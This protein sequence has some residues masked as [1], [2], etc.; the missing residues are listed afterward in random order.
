MTSQ[1]ESTGIR[2][3]GTSLTEEET[4]ALLAVVNTQ[5]VETPPA[6]PPVDHSTRNRVISTWGSVE[7]WHQPPYGH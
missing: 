4:A 3:H 7:G 2:V 5:L 1:P 6:E